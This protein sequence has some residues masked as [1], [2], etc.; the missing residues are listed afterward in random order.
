MVKIDYLNYINIVKDKNKL[1]QEKVVQ[2][3]S[4]IERGSFLPTA[5]Y[6]WLDSFK[7]EISNE[8]IDIYSHYTKSINLSSDPEFLIR[9]SDCI[10]YID[11]VNEEA[12]VIKCKSLVLLGKHSLA[13]KAFENFTREYS[14]IYAE[15]F[16]KDLNTIL[17]Q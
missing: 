4:I 9:L 10:F 11:P 2:L 5:E 13:Q 16:G 3:I 6:E 8:I 17:N 7:S 14:R 1:T 12:M 15:A